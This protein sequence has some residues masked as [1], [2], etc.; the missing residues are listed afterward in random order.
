[1]RKQT[2]EDFENK[3]R[4]ISDL[5]F[6]FHMGFI[7]DESG[8][9]IKGI[10]RSLEDYGAREDLSDTLIEHITLSGNNLKGYAKNGLTRNPILSAERLD[11]LYDDMERGNWD[12]RVNIFFHP[13]VSRS[14]IQKGL[15]SS[16]PDV[17]N[18]AGLRLN[19]F[20]TEYAG[21]DMEHFVE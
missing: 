6:P 5:L 18:A 17:V 7:N 11:K 10:L 21:Y 8:V 9:V 15:D 20:K 1:M 14:T 16:S 19:E 3:V 12:S 13:N 2:V 4:S